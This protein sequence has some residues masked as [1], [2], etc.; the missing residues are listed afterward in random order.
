VEC[1]GKQVF[2]TKA[3]AEKVARRSR[4]SRTAALSPYKCQHCNQWHI[5]SHVG[6]RWPMR[7]EERRKDPEN[8]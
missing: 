7:R 6:R 1:V 4:A 8:D 5:G 2:D 3:L